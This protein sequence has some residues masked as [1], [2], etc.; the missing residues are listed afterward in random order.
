MIHAGQSLGRRRYSTG[1]TLIELMIVVVILAFLAM[2]AYPNYRDVAARAQ[3]TEAKAALLQVAA[4]QER[5]YL[6]NNS[7]TTDMTKLG[8]DVATNHVT[9]SESYRV[10]VTAADANNFTATATYTRADREAGRCQTFQIDAR[11]ERLSAPENDC[12]TSTR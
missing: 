1:V 2:V 5:W 3:R 11:G 10:S 6:N 7:Y 9:P 12:W 8:F 4:Q